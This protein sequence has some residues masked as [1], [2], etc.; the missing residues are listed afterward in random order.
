MSNK[1]ITTLTFIVIAAMGILLVL[2][3]KSLLPGGDYG[4]YL[5]SGDVVNITIV[6][7]TNQFVL[8]EEESALF[9]KYINR[10]VPVERIR[11]IGKKE[12]PAAQKIIIL[13]KDGEKETLTPIVYVDKD[14]IFSAPQWNPKGYMMDLSDGEIKGVIQT[15]VH[16]QKST[17]L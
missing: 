14:L 15:T 6:T 11:E 9:I 8:D 7:E 17:H 13:M 16:E 3:I 12:Y 5:K 10:A 1:T 4:T 2:N